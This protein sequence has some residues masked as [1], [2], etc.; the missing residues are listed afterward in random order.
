MIRVYIQLDVPSSLEINCLYEVR[1]VVQET[2]QRA[3][4]E[5]NLHNCCPD[6]PN[7]E[8]TNTTGVLKIENTKV[9]LLLSPYKSK[10]PQ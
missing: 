6:L 4:D 3:I 9:S 2:T 10:L 7:V 8:I 5:L 1:K